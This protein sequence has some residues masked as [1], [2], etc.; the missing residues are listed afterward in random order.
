MDGRTSNDAR[1]LFAHSRRVIVE[2]I[3]LYLLS[4]ETVSMAA[5][6]IGAAVSAD[7]LQLVCAFVLPVSRARLLADTVAGVQGLAV[8]DRPQAKVRPVSAPDGR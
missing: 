4:V 7:G 1:D 3:V 8:P 2:S 6:A 5:A